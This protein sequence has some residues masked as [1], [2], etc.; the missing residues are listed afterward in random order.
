M[1]ILTVVGFQWDESKATENLRKH[2]IDFADAAVAIEDPSALTMRDE[3]IEEE[4]RWI[5][6]GTDALGRVLA[7]VYTWRDDNI[8]LISARLATPAERR[9]YEEMP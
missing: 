1:H 9:Q 2:G 7:V 5:A 6:L 4:D 3:L 8:R